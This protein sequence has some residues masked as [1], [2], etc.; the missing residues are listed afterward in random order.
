MPSH[1]MFCDDCH[2]YLLIPMLPDLNLGPSRSQ[3][4][5]CQMGWISDNDYEGTSETVGGADLDVSEI[6]RAG[7]SWQNTWQ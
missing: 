2:F 3:H 5:L 7:Y 4:P 6:L 1:R